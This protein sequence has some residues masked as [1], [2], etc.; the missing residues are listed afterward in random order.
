[1]SST[2]NLWSGDEDINND[3]IGIVPFG[4]AINSQIFILKGYDSHWLLFHVSK[5]GWKCKVYNESKWTHY[6]DELWRFLGA[7]RETYDE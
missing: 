3:Y 5:E 1:M 7:I 4:D 2:E 6:V